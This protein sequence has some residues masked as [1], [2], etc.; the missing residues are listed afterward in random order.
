[1]DKID[2]YNKLL[3]IR[4][5]KWETQYPYNNWSKEKIDLVEKEIYL[6]VSSKNIKTKPKKGGRILKI[7]IY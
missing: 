1:M 4:P 2:I 6:V 5:S 7:I 3:E